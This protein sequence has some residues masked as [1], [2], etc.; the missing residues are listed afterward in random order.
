MSARGTPI[1][2]TYFETAIPTGLPAYGDPESTTWG[3]ITEVLAHRREGFKDGP[4]F[5][6]ARFALER[7]GRHVRRIKANLLAR[8]AVALDIETSKLTGEIPPSPAEALS[9]AKALGIAAHVYTS[10]NHNALTDIR[11]RVLFPL[12]AEIS[13][14]LPAVEIVAERLGLAGVMDHSKTGAASL[15]YLPSCADDCAG[16]HFSESVDGTALDADKITRAGNKILAARRADAE[17]IASEAQAE[18]AARREAKIAE[19]FDPDDSLIEKLRSYLDVENILLSHGYEKSGQNYRH[20]NS[21]SGCFGANIKALGGIE[22]VFSH[23]ATD[24]LHASNLPVWC[25]GVTAVDAFD[26]TTILDFGGDRKKAMHNLAERFKLTKT[27]ERKA[28]A[29][30]LF[31]LIRKQAPQDEIETTAFTEGERLGLSR[32]E[33]CRVAMWVA[34]K[35]TKAVA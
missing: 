22:R 26:V 16:G 15:F 20:P 24:P 32:D 10:H 2:M 21:T 23:N 31:K 4:G 18:A 35:S 1:L 17:R 8:T 13:P 34:N 11:Y 29:G 6:P 7:D 9:R 28:L 27:V 33:V 14:E 30:M 5:A 25:G 19:G 3:A 12:S